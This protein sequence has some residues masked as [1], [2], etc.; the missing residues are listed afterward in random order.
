MMRVPLY[1]LRCV[2]IHSYY[3][4]LFNMA[5]Y[6]PLFI[7]IHVLDK[8]TKKLMNTNAGGREN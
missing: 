2:L 3:F 4:V 6:V 7:Q 5:C 1:A 8:L